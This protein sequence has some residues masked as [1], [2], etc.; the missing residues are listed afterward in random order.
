MDYQNH[1]PS[2]TNPP[3]HEAQPNTPEPPKVPQKEPASITSLYHFDT[4]KASKGKKKSLVLITVFS[5]FVNQPLKPLVMEISTQIFVG[6]S[7]GHIYQFDLFCLIDRG[8]SLLTSCDKLNDYKVL[9][10]HSGLQNMSAVDL[11]G[12]LLSS[13]TEAKHE[14]PTKD[15]TGSVLDDSSKLG[16]T[17]EGQPLTKKSSYHSITTVSTASIASD[18]VEGNANISRANSNASANSNS[19]GT[20]ASKRMLAIGKGELKRKRKP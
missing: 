13:S 12:S 15:S 19:S 7:N 14:I 17:Q 6:L 3:K 9:H 18:P 2:Q 5:V 20:I 10:L 8:M 1:A 4:Y 11:S 16:S